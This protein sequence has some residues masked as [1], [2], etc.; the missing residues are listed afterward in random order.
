[1]AQKRFHIAT[2]GQLRE[3]SQ[4]LKTGSVDCL[5]SVWNAALNKKGSSPWDHSIYAIFR[6][7][8][9]KAFIGREFGAGTVTINYDLKY[10]PALKWCKE[11]LKME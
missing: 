4:F 8:T 10:N 2:P 1:M 9:R 3:L 6:G 7:D 11:N 5:A